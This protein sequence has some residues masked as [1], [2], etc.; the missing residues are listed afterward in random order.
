MTNTIKLSVIVP[1]YNEKRYIVKL[2]ESLCANSYP[3]SDMEILLLDGGSTD[4][5]REIVSEYCVKYPHLRLVDNP[6]KFQVFALNVGIEQAKGQN[7]I[8]CDAH[9]EYPSDY[10]RTLSTLL[11]ELPADLGNVGIKADTTAPDGS[12]QSILIAYLLSS[13]YGVGNS[14]RSIRGKGLVEA[15]TLLFG[16]WRKRVFDD[17]GLFDTDFIR[18]QDYEHNLRLREKGYKVIVDTDRSFKYYTRSSYTKFCKMMFQYA[19]A[20]PFIIRKHRRS[21]NFRSLVPLIFFICTVL[22]VPVM[23][24]LSGGLL[25]GYSAFSGVVARDFYFKEGN[26]LLASRI[27]LYIF[28]QHLS[29]ALGT[30][31]GFFDAFVL[32]KKMFLDHTR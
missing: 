10:F 15:D 2:L 17:V 27:P 18:G 20:K 3:Y 1:I 30:L 32:R 16:A 31:V 7:I 21:L 8:R 23:P 13:K 26:A 11:D 24:T 25:L 12:D 9:A 5:T 14:H 28:S 6:N 4:G 19:Y 29:H 22:C